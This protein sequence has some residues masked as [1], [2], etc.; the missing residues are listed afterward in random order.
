M[1]TPVRCKIEDCTRPTL[2]REM[3]SSHYQR[4]MKYG[5]SLAGGI[6]RDK[7]RQ[8]LP[9]SVE[10][11]NE[12]R[13]SNTYCAFHWG[14]WRRYGDPLREPDKFAAVECTVG[15]CTG[16]AVGKGFCSSHYQKLVRHGDPEW[17]STPSSRRDETL[18]RRHQGYVILY[19]PEHPN[20]RKDGRVAEHVAVM[21]EMLG[22]PL[23]D[24]ENVHHRN[25][26]RDDNRPENLEL[27]LKTQP[28]GQRVADLVRFADSIIEQYGT[29]PTVYET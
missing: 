24:R 25:G 14:R 19:R 27:W 15:N 7:D 20:A 26:I 13:H 28:S 3:C 21:A 16:R 8:R 17:V 4:F 29:D 9:C 1:T 5:D 18:K 22:R 10:G 11:C 6:F 12:H 23:R 2:R